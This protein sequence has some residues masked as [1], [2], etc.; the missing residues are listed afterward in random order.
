V[1]KFQHQQLLV[2]LLAMQ[3]RLLL[4]ATLQLLVL[5]SAVPS[6]WHV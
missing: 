6:H 3:Q 2:V 5:V 1:P 4:Q